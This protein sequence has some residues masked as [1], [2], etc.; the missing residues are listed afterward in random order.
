MGASVK[1][2]KL[3]KELTNCEI[4]RLLGVQDGIRGELGVINGVFSENGMWVGSRSDPMHFTIHIMA[5]ELHERA[6]S[7][8][9]FAGES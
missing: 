2:F 3:R 1:K 8:S 7:F 5:T 6:L 9:D 4:A